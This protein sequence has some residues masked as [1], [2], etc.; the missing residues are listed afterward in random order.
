M[1]M[2]R[3]FENEKEGL[4]AARELKE[5]QEQCII[6]NQQKIREKKQQVFDLEQKHTGLKNEIMEK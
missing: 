3:D 1:N 5:A 2:I 4:F 6:E